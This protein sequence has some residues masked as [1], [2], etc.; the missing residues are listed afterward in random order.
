MSLKL[1]LTL[2]TIVGVAARCPH[3]KLWM[4]HGPEKAAEI[5]SQRHAA[6]EFKEMSAHPH[7]KLAD[8]GKPGRGYGT[9]VYENPFAGTTACVQLVGAGFTDSSAKAMCDNAMG[10][11]AVG[12]LAKGTECFAT[13]NPMLAGFCY[14]AEGAMAQAD[15]MLLVPSVPTMNSCEK[16]AKS[17]VQW[18]RGRFVMAGQCADG[19]A[20]GTPMVAS[21]PTA[22]GAPTPAPAP[23]DPCSIAPGP[24]GAAH[25]HARSPGYRKDCRDA[26]AKNSPYQWPL[27]WKADYSYDSIPVKG[28]GR[29]PGYSSRGTVYYDLGRNW[30]RSDTFNTTGQM[31]FVDDSMVSQEAHDSTMLH[32]GSEMFF[33]D[34]FKNGTSTCK[35][36]NLGIVGNIRPDWF[37][38]ARGAATGV[39]FMGN[40][41]IYHR[42]DPTLVKQWRKKDFADM[43]FVMSILEDVA[44]DGVHWPVQRNDPG[45]GFGDDGLHSFWNHQIL[46]DADQDLFLVDEGMDCEMMAGSESDGPP[47]E[48]MAEMIPSN[49]NVDETGWVELEYTAS[50]Q[51]KSLQRALFAAL[52]KGESKTGAMVTAAAPGVL[53][54]DGN[55]ELHVC[56]EDSGKMSLEAHFTAADDVWVS[57][58]VRPESAPDFCQ[59]LPANIKVAQTSS[60]G[61]WSVHEGELLKAMKTFEPAAA[62]LDKFE[63]AATELPAVV[64]RVDGMTTLTLA[65]HEAMQTGVNTKFIYAIGKKGSLSYHGLR[66][67]VNIATKSIPKC[68]DSANVELVERKQAIASS[69]NVACDKAVGDGLSSIEA[70]L[71]SLTSKL[72]EMSQVPK[73]SCKQLKNV[74][75]CNKWSVFCRWV[76]QGKKCVAR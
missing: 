62:V 21:A 76:A 69:E 9:C 65:D 33:I 35:K 18:S 13:S 43:Y 15:P 68:S 53:D 58:G 4:K 10:G 63:G 57:I 40:Q 73:V 22:N 46:S 55:G 71:A 42:G 45:E 3:S 67:C 19:S 66:G 61:E 29:K 17:C 72:E 32:R 28:A 6:H 75:G 54:L 51:G 16:I 41:H 37:M 2:A 1:F 5:L 50:P 47:T 64:E 44:E 52:D 39:Q 36:M 70:T 26:P 30:K 34:R 8:D 23:V 59:M 7:R 56:K 48:S 25:Q 74:G 12:I 20:S 27:Q 49:L 31:A 60:Y 11:M 14:T 38:D 24:M